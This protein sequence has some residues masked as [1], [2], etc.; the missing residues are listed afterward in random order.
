V[1][2]LISKPITALA[3]IPLV[4][5]IGEKALHVTPRAVLAALYI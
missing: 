4:Q 1:A 5:S 2:I 3:A